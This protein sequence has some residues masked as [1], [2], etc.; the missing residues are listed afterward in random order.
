MNL[1]AIF[2]LLPLFL[3]VPFMTFCCRPAEATMIRKMNL[4]ELTSQAELIISGR[5]TS[6]RTDWEDEQIFTYVTLSGVEVIKG[7]WESSEITIRLRGGTVSDEA[8]GYTTCEVA[9]MPEF[10]KTEGETVLFLRRGFEIAPHCPILGWGQGK[11]PR[12]EDLINE[13]NTCL[14]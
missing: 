5:V 3:L 10:S 9:G 12:T 7:S 13:I 1:K 8:G 4:G 6:I 11:L 14:P 2:R